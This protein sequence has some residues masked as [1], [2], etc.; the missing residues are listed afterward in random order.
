MSSWKNNSKQQVAPFIGTSADKPAYLQISL[1]VTEYSV[2]NKMA[3]LF[4]CTDLLI[5]SPLVRLLGA[6]LQIHYDTLV[7]LYV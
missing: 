3:V 1:T 2:F 5:L 4:V 6:A 7:T